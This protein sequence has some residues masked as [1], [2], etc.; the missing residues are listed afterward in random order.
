[1]ASV[2]RVTPYACAVNK[3]MHVTVNAYGL[4]VERKGVFSNHFSYT[5]RSFCF[6]ADVPVSGV[7]GVYIAS[8]H[9]PNKQ[10]DKCFLY[11]AGKILLFISITG[12]YFR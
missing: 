12:Y 2:S 8:S 5:G 3:L 6:S 9:Y 4:S 7:G 11:T 10:D 1:M